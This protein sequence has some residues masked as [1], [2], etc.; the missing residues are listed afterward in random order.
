M[1]VLYR[2]FGPPH[3]L[4]HVVALL[5]IGRRPERVTGRY[6]DIPDDLS[7]GQYVFVAGL[8]ALV[9]WGVTAVGLSHILKGSNFGEIILGFVVMSVGAMA[10]LG[11]I[12]DLQLIAARLIKK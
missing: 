9:F 10:G 4:L 8:P 3:E 2:I 12:G 1:D 5:L 7:T 11:T 6:V